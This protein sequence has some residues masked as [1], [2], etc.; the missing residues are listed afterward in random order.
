LQGDLQQSRRLVQLRDEYYRYLGPGEGNYSRDSLTGRYYHDPGGA[1]ERMLAS[2]G[3]YVPADEFILNLSGDWSGWRP[4]GL[5]G[6]LSRNGIADSAPVRKLHGYNLRATVRALE[7]VLT[8]WL[9]ASGSST[10]DRTLALSGQASQRQR[11]QA[12]LQTERTPFAELRLRA[13]YGVDDRENPDGQLDYT[14]RMRSLTAE[15]LVG[16]LLRLEA[17]L[18]VEWS[19]IAEPVSYPELGTFSLVALSGTLGRSWSFG[20]RWRLRARGG[21]VRRTASVATLPFDVALTR[22]S[23]LTPSAGIELSH[24]LSEIITFSGRYGF[25]DRP[26]RSADHQFSAEMRAFF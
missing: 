14:E 10:S 7:P 25:A 23:G 20:G 9:T 1:W 11:H 16:R 17:A 22:P 26:D 4:L 6:T 21:V 15:P 18:G 19:T 2:R 8:A 3:S 24:V 13:E 12:E 5:T